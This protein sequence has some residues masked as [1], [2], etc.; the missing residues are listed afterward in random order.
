[1]PAN[2]I[3][4]ARSCFTPLIAT[5]ARKEYNSVEASNHQARPGR[6][7]SCEKG[8]IQACTSADRCDP[9]TGSADRR[10]K[11]WASAQLCGVIDKHVVTGKTHQK[12]NRHR[13]NGFRKWLITKNKPRRNNGEFKRCTLELP[14]DSSLSQT[15]RSRCL[16]P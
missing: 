7:A 9:G 2:Q 5:R 8:Q 6:R 12:R 13:Q 3:W 14:A 10:T 11:S 4:P 15:R 16:G 1:M